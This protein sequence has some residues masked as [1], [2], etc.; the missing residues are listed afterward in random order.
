MNDIPLPTEQDSHKAA[1]QPTCKDKGSIVLPIGDDGI[2][3]QPTCEDKGPIVLTIG[4]VSIDWLWFPS[5]ISKEQASD[6]RYWHSRQCIE[7]FVLHGGAWYLD[8]FIRMLIGPSH[9][10]NVYTYRRFPVDRL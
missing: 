6:P 9:G 3:W 2:P 5:P 4:D 10:Q 1:P 8:N 7:T